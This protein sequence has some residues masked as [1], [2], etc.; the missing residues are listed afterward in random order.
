MQH[1]NSHGI[2]VH[3][4]FPNPAADRGFADNLDIHQLLVQ[5]PSSSFLFRISGN[6]W[7]TLG[8]FDQDIAVID[9]ALDAKKTDIVAWWN[10]QSGEFCLSKSKDM[11]AG[12][13]LFGVVTATIHQFRK[14]S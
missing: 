13:Q 12:S 11:P 1:D 8:I 14:N 6:D 7:Q 3:S 4:G 5:R 2:S 10:D 9:R